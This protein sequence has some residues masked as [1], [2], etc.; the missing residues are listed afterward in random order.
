MHYRPLIVDDAAISDHKVM[1]LL[2]DAGLASPEVTSE[3][4]E[5]A[6]PYGKPLFD[7]FDRGAIRGPNVG[8]ISDLV[9]AQID[10]VIDHTL[11]GAEEDLAFDMLCNTIGLQS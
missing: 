7:A 5:L 6:A 8:F 11:T 4:D 3:M 1:H 9:F 10:L 2:K